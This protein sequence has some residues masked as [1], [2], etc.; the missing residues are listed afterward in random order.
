MRDVWYTYLGL[1]EG[2]SQPV[3]DALKLGAET[4]ID[5]NFQSN[6]KT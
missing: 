5:D 2:E 1:W 4:P 6:K 3:E